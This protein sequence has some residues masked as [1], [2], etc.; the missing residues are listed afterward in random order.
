[1]SADLAIPFRL[2]PNGRPVEIDVDTQA[3]DLQRVSDVLSTRPGERPMIP[4][5]G[6]ADATFAG[7]TEADIRAVIGRWLSE[8]N[9][10]AV[11]LAAPSDGVLTARIEVSP[12]A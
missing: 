5:Y 10:R 8:I 11:G 9:V 4:L 1:M 6:L 12:R 3:H 7:V 2:A